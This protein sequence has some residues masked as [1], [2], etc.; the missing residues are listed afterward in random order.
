MVGADSEKS[1]THGDSRIQEE[2]ARIWK[3]ARTIEST[4]DAEGA[5]SLLR[6]HLSMIKEHF[7]HEE[8]DG[9]LYETILEAGPHH[10]RRLVG[11]RAQHGELIDKIC[12]LLQDVERGEDSANHLSRVRAIASFLRIHEA[13]EGSLLLEVFNTDIGVGD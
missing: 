11:L 13:E 8:G 2:H 1:I 7:A 12:T 6:E 9:G 4:D 10:E 3:I 5:T